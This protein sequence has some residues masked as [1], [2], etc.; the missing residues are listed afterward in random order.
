MFILVS[1]ISRNIMALKSWL[2]ETQDY[3]Y[4]LDPDSAKGV[5]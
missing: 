5:A 1:R 4:R 3:N 2:T